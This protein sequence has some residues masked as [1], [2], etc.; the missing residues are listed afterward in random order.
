MRE[1]QSRRLSSLVAW[2]APDPVSARLTRGLVCRP[3]GERPASGATMTRE[4]DATVEPT[5]FRKLLTF[6]WTPRNRATRQV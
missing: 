3:R 5:V 1:S 4:R 2:R 6:L